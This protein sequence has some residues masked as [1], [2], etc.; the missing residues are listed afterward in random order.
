MRC[1]CGHTD[2]EHDEGILSCAKCDCEKFK[3]GTDNS[4]VNDSR[5]WDG[6]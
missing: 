3:F 1:T 6:E 2:D 5:D 4:G